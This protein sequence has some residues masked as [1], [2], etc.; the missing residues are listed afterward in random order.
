[1]GPQYNSKQQITALLNGHRWTILLPPIAPRARY[2]CAN[3]FLHPQHKCDQA[4]RSVAVP[5]NSR[6]IAAFSPCAVILGISMSIENLRNIAIIAHVDHGKTTLVDKLL[7]QSGTLD[8]KD[9]GSERLMDSN[10]QEKE[11]GITILAKNT[12]INWNDYRINIVDTPG[13]AD[14]GGEVERVMSMADSVLLLVD[15]QEGPMPQ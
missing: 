4:K 15:A 9:V 6:I 10:D 2:Y 13:H 5:A 14:F 12:A 11:R 1:M 8:R 7:S 3:V